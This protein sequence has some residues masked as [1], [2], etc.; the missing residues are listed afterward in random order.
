MLLRA[1]R[2]VGFSV[3]HSGKLAFQGFLNCLLLLPV[4]RLPRLCRSARLT[5]R[6]ILAKGAAAGCRKGVKTIL[7]NSGETVTTEV[8]KFFVFA[9]SDD[10][11]HRCSDPR[12]EKIWIFLW[13]SLGGALV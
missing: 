5:I 9:I 11:Q 2:G 3:S 13:G 4:A 10:S 8:L 1:E 12:A 7:P 6:D